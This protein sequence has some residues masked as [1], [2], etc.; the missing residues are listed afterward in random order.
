MRKVEKESSEEDLMYLISLT[1][2][3]GI[4]HYLAKSLLSYCGS[5]KAVFKEKKYLLKKIPGIGALTAENIARFNDFKDA[6][7]EIELLKKHQI[8]AI[9]CFDNHYPV[10]LKEIEDNPVVIYT[11]G[12]PDINRKRILSIVGTRNATSYG[13]SFTDDLISALKPYDVIVVSGLAAGTDTNVHKACIKMN[14][15]TIGVLGHGFSTVYPGANRKLA[16]EMILNG[17]LITEF[18]YHTPGNRE[19][20]P[21]RNRLVAGMSDAVIVVESGIRGGSMITADLANQYNRDVFALPGKISDNFSAGCNRLISINQAGIIDSISGLI[22]L[23]G[24]D[25][26]INNKP[27]FNPDLFTSL[28]SSES[29][30]VKCL[31]DGQKGID[32]LHYMT[33]LPMSQLSFLLLDMEFKGLIKNYPGKVYAL[34]K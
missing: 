28:N 5:A 14:V 19:N 13:K 2:V 31:S 18:R 7:D 6:E 21:R 15:P 17:G 34:N 26:P 33:E 12:S 9:T 16:N 30:I 24:Y 20:F 29:M 32:Q 3:A 1:M 25:V 4:G 11:K 23:L 10:K 27:L 8:Q 22:R